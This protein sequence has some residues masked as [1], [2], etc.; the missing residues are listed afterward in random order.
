MEGNLVIAW[1]IIPLAVM[2]SAAIH[3]A[4][5]REVPDWHWMALGVSGAVLGALSSDGFWGSRMLV[6]AGS[7]VLVAYMLD[8]RISGVRAVPVV[9]S[10]V[11]MFV[12]AYALSPSDYT[13]GGLTVPVMFLLFYLMYRARLLRGGADA[14]CMMSLAIAFPVYPEWGPVPLVCSPSSPESVVLNPSVAILVVGLLMSLASLAWTVPRSLGDGCGLTSYRMPI[15][16]ARTGFVWPVERMEG[17]TRVR[18]GASDDKDRILD[19][20]EDAG[21]SDV[22]VTPMI[23]F[24]VP[25]AAAAYLVLLLG[26]PLFALVTV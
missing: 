1:V 10:A 7:L 17:G 6:A 22:A 23:P 12:A 20:L 14:K 4:R 24:V 8:E 16:H 11:C 19:D 21:F 13:I 2:L 9:S 25:L 5:S 3:D 26:N 15:A 18:C